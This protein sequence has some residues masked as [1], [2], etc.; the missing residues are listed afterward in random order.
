MPDPHAVVPP[1]SVADTF[2][3]VIQPVDGCIFGT[4]YTDSSM[5]DGP[6]YLDG[7][8]RRLGWAFVAVDQ[9]GSITASARGAPA[10]RI[11]IVYGASFGHFGRRLGTLP[12]VR[13]FALIAYES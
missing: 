4:V 2:Q 13:P 3:W 9:G 6:P 7:L 12:L 1:T 8:S 5:I 11:D 10:L